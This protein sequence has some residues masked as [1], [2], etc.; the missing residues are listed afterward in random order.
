[1]MVVVKTDRE[2][3]PI[4]SFYFYIHV[5][6]LVRKACTFALFTVC[7]ILWLRRGQIEIQFLAP[8]VLFSQE[9]SGSLVHV[10]LHCD[11][12]LTMRD[13]KFA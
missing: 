10:T 12:T 13:Y 5:H 2:F 11:L 4:K 6:V 9:K 3:E 1:M 8:H 7:N